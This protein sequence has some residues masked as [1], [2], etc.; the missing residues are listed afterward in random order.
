[1]KKKIHI[2]CNSHLDPIWIWGRSSGR[3]AW[4]NTMHSVVRI[5]EENPDLK[6]TCSTAAQYRYAEECDP[7][8]FRKIAGLVRDKRWEIVGGWEVQP[9]VIIS[10]PQS[11]IH[12][13]LSA[14]KYFRDRFGVEVTTGYC[15]DSFGHS[16][17]LPKILNAS[18]FTHYVYT[19]SQDTPPVF[20]WVADDGSAVT[21][22][23]IVNFYGTGAGLNFLDM[24]FRKH[25]ET[26]LE[27]QAMF[28]GV[29]DHGGGISRKELARIRE[30]QKEYDIVFSTL[31]EY[32]ET[33]KNIDLPVISGELGP[34]FRGC[35]SNC[36]EIKR[37]ISRATRKLLTAEKLG[38][39]TEELEESWKELC[40]LNFHDILPGTSIKEA[41]EKDIFPGIGGVESEACRLIDRQLFRRASTFD[42][43][44]M[45]E[46]GVYCWN[47]HTFTHKSIISFDGF[48]DPNRNGKNFNALRDREGNEYP[49]QILPPA[50]GFG[51]TGATWCKLTAAIDLP[52]MGEKL[53][54]YAVS[55]RKF[56]PVGFARS[57]ELLKKLS[58][59]ICFD[60]SRTW[61]FDL[62]RFDAKLGTAELLDI[63]EYADGPVCSIL[64][65]NY[66]YGNS[67]I[68]LDLY[69]YAGIPEIGIKVRLDW[70]EIKCALKLVW[71]HGLEKP[72][73]ST[74][75]SAAAVTRMDESSYDWEAVEWKNGRLVPKY[76]STDEFSMI[77]WCA[78]GNKTK[79]AAFF[80]AD[81]HSC[82]HADNTMRLTLIRPVMYA[83]HAP[84]EPNPES[85][86]MDLGVSERWIW[87]AEYTDTPAACIPRLANARLING[88][89]R[90]VSA[91]IPGDQLENEFMQLTFDHPQVVILELRRNEAGK[92]EITLMNNGTDLLE[93]TLPGAGNVILP[94]NSMK[95]IEIS[96][97]CQAVRRESDGCGSVRQ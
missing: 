84:F 32:F 23:H 5:M 6:F 50:T 87:A 41:F 37:K 47:E 63:M 15:V 26:P 40:F 45:P 81:L 22:L 16:S 96:G 42:T 76:P 1:M 75:S 90:E 61:G 46:G 29:G 67:T 94:G 4:L 68:R 95:I 27:H 10:R 93:V 21:A 2:I 64:R 55:D 59:E 20:K 3:S 30:L 88:E 85:G 72:F 92:A 28:F 43:T 13:A 44:F 52:P 62:T 54:A 82:D 38:V 31:S 78:A 56:V 24:S 60:N 33:I 12:Q 70:H 49:L 25:L 18:G 73:F 51:P 79:C 91:H 74:G 57:R 17:G 66:R 77:D 19:R 69:D 35:Y 65:A 14:K 11:L 34:I 53:F 89:V 86:W 36:H 39:K 48:G 80:A 71:D 7:A 8:L 97:N 83:D 58:F 9:D